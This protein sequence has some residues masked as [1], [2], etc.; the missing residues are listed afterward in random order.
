[1]DFGKLIF[2]W[3]LLAVPLPILLHLFFKRRKQRVQFSTLLFFVRRER[4]FAYRR[5]LLELLLLALRV[6]AIL[7]LVFALSRVFFKKFTFIAG[8]GTEAVIVLDD[9]MSMQRRLP[10][11]GTAYEFAVH[12]A[13]DI[14]NSLAGDDGAALVFVSGRP[15]INLTR[16]KNAVLRELRQSYVTGA[17][18]SLAAAMQNAVDQLRK[19]PGVNREIYLLSDFQKTA[20][21]SRPLAVGGLK[22]SRVF[23]LPLRGPQA[24]VA[25][26]TATL[27]MAPRI[28]GRPVNIPFKITN[29]GK[30]DKEVKIELEI[31]GHVIQSRHVPVSGGGSAADR[32]AWVPQRSG[33]VAGSVRV[34][35]DAIPLDDRAAFTFNVSGDVRVILAHDAAAAD[36]EP[37]YFLRYAIDPSRD[38]HLYGI[39][40]VSVPLGRVN[41][42]ALKDGNILMLAQDGKLSPAVAGEI[43]KFL[44]NGGVLVTLPRTAA[45]LPD[46]SALCAAFNFRLVSPYRLPVDYGKNGLLFNPPLAG[47]N[48]LLQLELL[49]WRRLA[50]LVTVNNG[51]VL[52]ENNG[53]PVM[54]EQPAGRG[55][56]IALAFDLRRECTNWPTLKSI[57]VMAVSLINYAAGNQELTLFRRCGEKVELKGKAISFQDNHGRGGTLPTAN[58][59]AVWGDSW[60]PGVTVFSGADCEAVVVQPDGGESDLTAVD[61]GGIKGFFDASVTLLDPGAEI[62]GQVAS[63]RQGTE[64]S[65]VLLLLLLAVLSGEFLLGANGDMVRRA[66]KQL[67]SRK[68]E[69]KS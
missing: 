36:P 61:D 14:L 22:N 17:T 9:S 41:A 39:S 51:R 60:L 68:R 33:R 10:S 23:C 62:A 69:V 38:T 49:K 21:P 3:G 40:T 24:N 37:F 47:F 54:V 4:Y 63:L 52:A 55:R 7:L 8:A 11:G 18:G 1:M 31:D 32:F 16:D 50:P 5:R 6:L 44:D 59:H 34:A 29:Y 53:I 12:K 64:L 20:A 2:L 58:G 19:A 30:T 35:D 45:S 25:V 57:P 42:A 26:E 65:G 28:V 67:F 48:E 15:G 66:A 13:E 56:W 46:Y 27:D 43:K